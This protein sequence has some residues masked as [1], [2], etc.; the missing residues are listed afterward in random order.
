MIF[1][2]KEPKTK[3]V[4]LE[5]D[6]QSDCGA[7]L[8]T[9]LSDEQRVFLIFYIQQH[10][11]DFD[12]S[13]VHVRNASEDEYVAVVTFYHYTSLKFGMPNDEAINGHR[14]YKLGLQPYTNYEVQNSEWIKELETMN[15]VHPRH[16]P[17]RYS[18]FK[19]F[20]FCFHDSIFEIVAEKFDFL[21]LSETMGD[22][23]EKYSKNL[24]S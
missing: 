13:S 17:A 18:A 19:H 10:N 21:L 2:D 24:N 9:L 3:L 8:P 20:I 5:L 22:V 15:R 4:E 23:V 1:M 7:P 16:D 14:Y 11:P 6:F 12:G